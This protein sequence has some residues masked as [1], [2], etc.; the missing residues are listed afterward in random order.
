MPNSWWAYIVEWT[1]SGTHCRTF[2]VIKARA[3]WKASYIQNGKLSPHYPELSMVVKERTSTT[4]VIKKAPGLLHNS[5]AQHQITNTSTTSLQH[6]G[7][8]DGLRFYCSHKACALSFA[9]VSFFACP[10][11]PINDWLVRAMG[12][13]IIQQLRTDG[14]FYGQTSTT[15]RPDDHHRF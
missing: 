15:T 14:G 12:I 8:V 1:Y 6:N 2:N 10:S 11:D 5:G 4:F 3:R 7:T 9:C 13:E